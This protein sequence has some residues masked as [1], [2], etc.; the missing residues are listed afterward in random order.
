MDI[1]KNSFI[2][3]FTIIILL[4]LY[5]RYFNNFYEGF[6]SDEILTL[7]ISDPF[8][9]NQQMIKNWLQHDSSP[10]IYFYLTKAFLFIF[11]S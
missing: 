10:I 3:F 11:V 9:D 7:I 5:F 8:I 4:G 1:K 2:F 6:W